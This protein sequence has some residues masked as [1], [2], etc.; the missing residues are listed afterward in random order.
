[1]CC[2][3]LRDVRV[4]FSTT[5]SEKERQSLTRILKRLGGKDAG[6]Q[7]IDFSH[8]VTMQPARRDKELGFKKSFSTLLAMAAGMFLDHSWACHPHH[9]FS[10]TCEGHQTCKS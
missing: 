2:V 9:I 5:V 3:R 6:K 8:F 7:S 10:I 1:M 4:L